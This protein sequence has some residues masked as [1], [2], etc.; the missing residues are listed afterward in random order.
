MTGKTQLL[1][2]GAQRL[3]KKDAC[4]QTLRH[5]DCAPG[6]CCRLSLASVVRQQKA[7]WTFG[8]DVLLSC[9]AGR[10]ELQAVSKLG[11]TAW[12]RMARRCT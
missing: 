3:A 5:A 12:H 10:A 11:V 8:Q 7:A 1:S 6:H 2:S 4:P 9:S